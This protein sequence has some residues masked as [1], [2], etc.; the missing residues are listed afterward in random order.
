MPFDIE[1]HG[2]ELQVKRLGLQRGSNDLIR[3]YGAYQVYVDG[4]PVAGL[5]GHI[6]ECIGPGDNSAN[7]KRRH[8]R[9]REGRYELSTQY[10]QHYRSAGF[11]ADEKHPPAFLILGTGERSAVL[12]HPGHHPHLYLSS[13][14]C[15]NP[16]K[17]LGP[18]G[19]MVF[20]E[21]RARV[22]AMIDSLKQ[23]DPAAFGTNKIG[24]DT[25]IADAHIVVDGE[26]MTEV[27]DEA[28]A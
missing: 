5:S 12:V 13:I 24:H 27:S 21:S 19:K 7:G 16:T 17:P 26:P 10:G 22:I 9:I 11:T 8:S 1:G 15:F 3:T 25:A 14:G 18:D 6:C 23:H 20:A 4:E 28:V 2:W